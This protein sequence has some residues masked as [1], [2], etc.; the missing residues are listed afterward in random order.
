MKRFFVVLLTAAFCTAA[1]AACQAPAS[2]IPSSDSTASAAGDTTQIAN[3][4]T[5]YD[6]L[7]ELNQAAGTALSSLAE[8]PVT[9][10]RFA[11]LADADYTLAEYDFTYNGT[12]FTLRCAP[13]QGDI[14]GIWQDGKALGDDR[15]A[16][17]LFEVTDNGL[18]ARW[19]DDTGMQYSLFGEGSSA[20][21]FSAVRA[22][23]GA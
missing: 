4:W 6:S 15:T 10:E 22:A 14:S 11:A 8:L 18:W 3:P 17:S 23:L 7:D 2:D 1:L 16:D 21:D 9:E 5:E 20:E 19:F 13:T 12:K